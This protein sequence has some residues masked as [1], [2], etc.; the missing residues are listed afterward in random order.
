MAAG[1]DELEPLVRQRARRRHLRLLQLRD[2]LLVPLRS[3]QPVDAFA[4][5]RRHEPRTG[6]RGHALTWPVLERRD[7]RV[8]HALLR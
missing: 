8:L 7:E 1:E 6:T 3:P 2:L 5:R 4:F